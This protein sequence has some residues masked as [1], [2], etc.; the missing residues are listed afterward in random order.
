MRFHLGA[1]VIHLPA[2]PDPLLNPFM[3]VSRLKLKGRSLSD[4]LGSWLISW[5]N[6][7]SGMNRIE[8]NSLSAVFTSGLQI[9]YTGKMHNIVRS[10]DD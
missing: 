6:F 8:V 10:Y 5:L 3:E 9:G 4:C 2:L 1:T 7:Q